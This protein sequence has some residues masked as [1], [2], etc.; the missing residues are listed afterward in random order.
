[1]KYDL[2]IGR[3]GDVVWSSI[4]YPG[5]SH[6]DTALAMLYKVLQNTFGVPEGVLNRAAATVDDTNLQAG[7]TVIGAVTDRCHLGFHGARL[8]LTG[9]P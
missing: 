1:M 9:R 5:D 6:G 4:G 8:P 3:A 2:E 7:N